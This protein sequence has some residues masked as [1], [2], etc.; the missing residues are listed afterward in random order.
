MKLPQ[1]ITFKPSNKSPISFLPLIASVPA[2]MIRLRRLLFACL[3]R[4]ERADD[5]QLLGVAFTFE[6]LGWLRG[7]GCLSLRDDLVL[8]GLIQIDRSHV[9]PG[10]IEPR[11][12]L[13]EEGFETTRAAAEMERAERT[14]RRP[15]Q[16]DRTRHDI[17]EL[18]DFDDALN[19]EVATFPENRPL[20][21]V[22]DEAGHFLAHDARHL[23]ERRVE[24]DRVIH[25]LRARLLAGNDF[26][27]WNQMRRVEGM[28]HQQPL[29][30]GHLERLLRRGLGG[31]RRK[32]QC[33]LSHDLADPPHKSCLNSIRSGPFS[34]T[35]SAPATER[36][37][38][39]SKLSFFSRLSVGNPS[40]L[41]V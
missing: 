14:V 35:R 36:S 12:E 30:P 20:Q 10:L 16:A 23:A 33:V 8:R 27:Q 15:A 3:H 38:S 7:E 34:C 22:R 37:R 32:H 40:F 18:I 24:R 41:S 13:L 11:T 19:D 21:A 31:A 25:R 9:L 5:R 17:V 4:L 39:A 26:D 6:L 28:P 2:W 1:S 29:G